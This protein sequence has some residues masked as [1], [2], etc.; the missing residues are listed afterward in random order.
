MKRKA[1][2]ILLITAAVTNWYCLCVAGDAGRESL[3]SV[4][5]GARALAMGGGFTSLADDASAVFYNP[6]GLPTLEYHEIS[7][8]HM[9][10]F[11]GTT[12]DFASWTYPVASLGGFGAA[13]MRIGTNDIIRSS[14]FVE[15]EPF[16]YSQSQFLV[17]YGRELKEGFSL[18][19]SL[20]TINQNLG[21]YYDYGVGLDLGMMAH[22]NNRL[23][24]GFIIRDM[25]P[26][27]IELEEK[28]EA[29]P[30]TVVSGLSLRN[31][32]LT[33]RVGLVASLELEKIEERNMKVHT[34]AEVVFDK[35][36]AL[37]AGYDRDNLSFGAGF[38]Y[39]RL[40][41]DYAYKILDYIEDSHRFSI[42]FLLGP[43]V[44]EQV[45]KKRFEE[46]Q[47]RTDLLEDE[48]QRQLAFYKAKADKFYQLRQFDSA[49]TYYQRAL[50][51]DEGNEE[52]IGSIAEIE[53]ARRIQEE[54]EQL[55]RQ[56]ELE[57][58]KTC[59]NYLAQ[60]QSFYA[61]NYYTAALDMLDL[62]F[63]IDPIHPAAQKLKFEI[64]KAMSSD[65]NLNLEIAVVAE[66]EGQFL[67]AL[68]AYE[69]ILGYDPTNQKAQEGKTRVAKKLDLMQ[70]LNR[71]LE[72][73]KSG[74][75]AQARYLFRAVL[76]IDPVQPV[77][78][79]YIKKID[80]AL[81]KPPT[82][83]DIQKDKVFWQLY[84]DG[85]RY[86]RN[87]EYQKAIEAWEKVLQAYPNNSNTLDN[88]EQA[89]LR[90]QSEKK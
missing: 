80:Q 73:F 90:L 52:I 7:F 77:A 10:L 30:V 2:F 13:Y 54:R 4:G 62:I 9:T 83:E 33:E 53:K 60:A 11:E 40:K 35:T 23:T 74:K 61:K 36:Y 55:H 16:D 75:Y 32:K 26:P 70:Q 51:F 65:I 31:T 41:I 42:S 5:A 20:K 81:A 64:E 82:L 19:V 46:S 39:R 34:G 37:R 66:R 71:G 58:K 18:G 3:F 63:D 12:Y 68:E 50:V 57:I 85:L 22:L 67:K 78:A 89:R 6:A 8:M 29:Q 45:R 84:L 48:R 27:T 44:S 87:K 24:A 88:I 59:E 86:M 1:R 17:S 76:A 15:Q 69:R 38:V 43:A 56:T 28:S 21:D 72:L 47:R 14:G 25:I 49:L 79:E